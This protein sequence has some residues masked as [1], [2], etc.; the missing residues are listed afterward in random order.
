MLI[1]VAA[2]TKNDIRRVSERKRDES[3]SSCV[4]Y[5]WWRAAAAIEGQRCLLQIA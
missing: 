4:L 5:L 2:W 1:V 3:R